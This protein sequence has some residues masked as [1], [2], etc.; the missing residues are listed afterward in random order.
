MNKKEFMSD[1]QKIYDEVQ[2]RDAKLYSYYDI[3]KG[4]E[5]KEAQKY[6]DKLLEVMNLKKSD[7]YIMAGLNRLVSLKEDALIRAMEND[8]IDED[9]IIEKMEIAYDFVSQ[10]YMKRFE[11]LITWIVENNLLTPFYRELI[12]GIHSIGMVMSR[13]HL[14]WKSHILDNINRELF[15]LFN[16]DE[17]KIYEMLHNKELFE[18]EDNQVADRAYSVI[19]STKDGFKK[20]AYADAFKK[21]VNEVVVYINI[22][23][24]SLRKLE[25][26]VFNQ[27][28]EWINYL[29]NLSK[30][31]AHTDTNS[32]V[33]YWADVDRAWMR[34]KTPIQLG[35]PLEYYE[36]RYRKAV[37]L[38]WDLRIV[39]P[40][41]QN[42]NSVANMIKSFASE[43]SIDFG[44]KGEKLYLKSLSQ[45]EKTQLYIGRPILFYGAELTGLFSA[46]VVPNDEKV[47]NEMG[48]KIFAYADFV[49]EAKIHKPTLQIH[50]ELFGEEF[51]KKQKVLIEKHPNIWHKIYAISTIGHEFGHILWM[52]EDTETIM[53]QKGEFKNIEEFKATTGGLMGF[54]QKEIDELKEHIVDD[55][56]FRAVSLIGWK[57]VEEVLPYYCEGLIHLNILKT[58]G[59]ISINGFKID[60][61]YSRYEDMKE[62]YKH[63]YKELVAIYVEK[64]DA[65]EYLYRFVT[66]N[67]KEYLPS[68][69]LLKEFTKIYYT[70]YKKNSHIIA[71]DI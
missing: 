34:V 52:D 17:E 27:K 49:R 70:K 14:E 7:E 28:S 16:G 33:K 8:G 42:E 61:D 40:S 30:A 67:G 43:L 66:K 13:W 10:F 41:L 26:E 64:R 1:L 15:E 37:A 38:E 48:K 58:S 19:I 6:I 11:S 65:S 69:I 44:L 9:T 18:M 29:F 36:D 71:K 60:I 3:T 35:H 25:D 56:V 53:N 4:V 57:E 5:N 21:E 22:L 59:I 32:I 12:Q 55:L 63:Y 46:Q 50:L 24:S 39:N 68:D 54:F 45:I 20:V 2:R 51:I 47:S 23:I 31:M 62:L